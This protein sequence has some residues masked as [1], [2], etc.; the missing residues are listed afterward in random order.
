[1]N[2]EH[3]AVNASRKKPVAPRLFP[4]LGL[5]GSVLLMWG[6]LA[7]VAGAL[8]VFGLNDA[9]DISTSARV[10]DFL[11]STLIS[12]IVAFWGMNLAALLSKYRP[13][14]LAGLVFFPE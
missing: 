5:V 1:V 6:F 3:E 7:L 10:I 11:F 12:L 8:V 4:W 13:R 14:F 2:A 9:S